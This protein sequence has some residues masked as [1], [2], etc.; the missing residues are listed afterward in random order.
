MPRATM[1]SRTVYAFLDCE[2][3]F[4]MEFDR[5]MMMILEMHDN[6]VANDCHPGS[7]HTLLI[8]TAAYVSDEDIGSALQARMD[9]PA[10]PAIIERTVEALA[11]GNEVRYAW[12]VNGS[13]PSWISYLVD[14]DNSP[15]ADFTRGW[16]WHNGTS[17]YRA[18]GTIHTKTPDAQPYA[19]RASFEPPATMAAHPLPP[20]GAFTAITRDSTLHMNIEVFEEMDCS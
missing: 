8:L 7:G 18:T 19:S 20:D 14:G 12:N 6:Y 4:W 10:V 16:A 2:R 11:I 5:P 9:M 1:F 13:K 15:G 17:L 3:F